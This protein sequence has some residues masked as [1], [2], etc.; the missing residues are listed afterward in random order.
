MSTLRLEGKFVFRITV[1]PDKRIRLD[2]EIQNA[3]GVPLIRLESMF[4]ES[5]GW[6][7]YAPVYLEPG[8]EERRGRV[9]LNTILDPSE[10]QWEIRAPRGG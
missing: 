7:V 4:V 3:E 10:V 2:P 6:A 5:G 8:A 1:L 9:L